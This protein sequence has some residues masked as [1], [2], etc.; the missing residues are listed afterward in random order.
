MLKFRSS[1]TSS[2]TPMRVAFCRASRGQQL[3]WGGNGVQ[4]LIRK[5]GNIQPVFLFG[6]G[7]TIED[8]AEN[9]S[10]HSRESLI[11]GGGSWPLEK[12]DTKELKKNNNE[13][14]T[15]NTKKQQT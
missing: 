6:E 5:A 3:E 11:Q 10:R 13:K 7:S 1:V 8:L 14:T 15:T 4:E 2:P 12:R 9:T